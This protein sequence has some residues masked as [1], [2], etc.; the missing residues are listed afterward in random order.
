MA[1]SPEFQAEWREYL[2]NQKQDLNRALAYLKKAEAFIREASFP[3]QLALNS[4]RITK[5]L[6][7]A[8]LAKVVKME[9]EAE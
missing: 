3:E 1:D 7:E 6:V 9:V 5:V 2:R 8:D 4:V